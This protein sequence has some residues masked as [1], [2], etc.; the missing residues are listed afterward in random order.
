M[1]LQ[2]HEVDKLMLSVFDKEAV[3]DA[4]PAA[5]TGGSACSMSEFDDGSAHSFINFD[6][7]I[8]Q[9]ENVVT[10]YDLI[11]KQEIVRQG[12]SGTYKEPMAKP[13][14]L[15]GLLALC[16]GLV[17]STQD[18]ALTAYR[19]KI[20]RSAAISLPSIGAEAKMDSGRQY[21]FTG[22]KGAGYTIDI[23]GP[24]WGFE[25]QLVGSGS[26][27]TAAD[28]FTASILENWLRWGDSKVFII[29]TAG[30][31]ITIGATPTQ[32]ASNIGGGAVDLSTRLD[33]FSHKWQN[34][35]E[36]E[37]AYKA[38][39]GLVRKNFHPKKRSG[40]L[41]LSIECDSATEATELDYYL[42][43]KK[44]ALEVNCDSGTIIAA[45]GVFKFGFIL[46]IPKFQLKPFKRDQKSQQEILSYEADIMEDGTNPPVVAFVYN[47]QPVYLA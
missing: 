24:Y 43:Q 39:T 21:K 32:G 47:A 17:V 36:L 30:T 14:T 40:S 16:Q 13:N 11:T 6:D 44:L 2:R 18:G 20:T 4:G 31:P 33:T 19:H 15:A 3:F 7:T 26:R 27:A 1:G 10:G 35:F 5:W 12:V 9:D 29:D 25:A 22:L 42:L 41:S 37:A 34:N 45:T 46:I 8:Q 38:S 23:N 28:A